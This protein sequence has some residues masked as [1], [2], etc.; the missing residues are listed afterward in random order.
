MNGF[1]HHLPL[2][3]RAQVALSTEQRRRLCVLE[4]YDLS[5]VRHRLLAEGLLPH[6]L[7][8]EA[9][10][11]VRRFLA[12]NALLEQ[13]VGMISKQVDAVWHT[14]LLFSRLYADLCQ[15]VFGRFLHHEPAGDALDGSVGA[16]VLDASSEVRAFEAAYRRVF[17][18]LGRLWQWERVAAP[19][20]AAAALSARLTALAETL[21]PGEL[22][23]LTQVLALA[24]RGYEASQ[25]P[26]S[27]APAA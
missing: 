9:S 2:G 25:A 23:A 5:A 17:G 18:P 11:E 3:I 4:A 26:P 21:P 7:V 1:V 10:L 24:A 15:Q 12:L 16:V 14:C 19:E 22:D 20:H 8:D 6:A 13:P 27:R